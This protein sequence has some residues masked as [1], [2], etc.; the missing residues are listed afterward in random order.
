MIHTLPMQVQ[1]LV[2]PGIRREFVSSRTNE[3]R[4]PKRKPLHL[5]RRDEPEPHCWILPLFSLG[6]VTL[7]CAILLGLWKLGELMVDASKYLR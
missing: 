2:T 7:L 3:T 6:F 4:Q 5:R 1:H